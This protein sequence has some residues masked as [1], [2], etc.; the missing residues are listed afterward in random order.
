MPKPKK[1]DFIRLSPVEVLGTYDDREQ[2]LVKVDGHEIF[3]SQKNI[4]EVIPPPLKVGDR[5]THKWTE[6]KAIFVIDCIR[7]NMTILFCS[8]SK[9]WY[10]NP[11]HISHLERVP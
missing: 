8:E 5:V 11:V 7:N 1:G 6:G 10:P 3:V 9:E 2:F 4:D